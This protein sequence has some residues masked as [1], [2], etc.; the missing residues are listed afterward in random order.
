MLTSIHLKKLPFIKML[1][2][3]WQNIMDY[4]KEIFIILVFQMVIVMTFC[5]LV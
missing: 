1:I 3:L 4:L 5:L 2:F